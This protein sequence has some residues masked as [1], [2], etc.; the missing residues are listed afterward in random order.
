MAENIYK[1]LKNI[2]KKKIANIVAD[3]LN[4]ISQVS[5]DQNTEINTLKTSFDEVITSRDT[6]FSEV[7]TLMDERSE[8]YQSVITILYLSHFFN[9]AQLDLYNATVWYRLLEFS[10]SEEF[11]NTLQNLKYYITG[12]L[13]VTKT[14]QYQ[15]YFQDKFDTL[16][17]LRDRNLQML[18]TDIG[19]ALQEWNGSVYVTIEKD[20]PEN[21]DNFLFYTLGYLA[22]ATGLFF[23]YTHIMSI[24][25]IIETSNRNLSSFTFETFADEIEKMKNNLKRF[26]I[27]DT[28]RKENEASYTGTYTQD[29]FDKIEIYDFY[30]LSFSGITEETMEALEDDGSFSLLFLTAEDIKSEL[31]ALIYET[32]R[33]ITSI[34]TFLENYALF[35]KLPETNIEQIAKSINTVLDNYWDNLS[36]EDDKEYFLIED[37]NQPNLKTFIYELQQLSNTDD[38]KI[39]FFEDYYNLILLYTGLKLK[40]YETDTYALD[41]IN[42]AVKNLVVKSEV[43]DSEVNEIAFTNL[44]VLEENLSEIYGINVKDNVNTDLINPAIKT[45][46]PKFNIIDLV[47]IS[48]LLDYN[49]G[50]NDSY[51][52]ALGETTYY[53]LDNDTWMSGTI[54]V[55]LEAFINIIYMSVMEAILKQSKNINSTITKT[56]EVY[57]QRGTNF[58]SVFI[59]MIIRK[60]FA[61]LVDYID[62]QTSIINASTITLMQNYLTVDID[63][64]NEGILANYKLVRSAFYTAEENLIEKILVDG[65]ELRTYLETIYE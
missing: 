15:D 37:A 28:Y 31:N 65:N 35:V 17:A 36:D 19:P 53:N 2:L 43:N 29:I 45:L 40:T 56:I 8:A 26:M 55:D 58:K 5:K 60:V 42:Y 24:L 9:A 4:D 1:Q 49:I 39:L 61:K 51:W 18:Q 63:N 54:P 38:E 3:E 23:N 32:L 10:K 34:N 20:D 44:K 16:L 57:Q 7:E 62:G 6:L 46:Y 52:I 48:V 33:S 30:L 64:V 27:L 59:E 14:K 11:T 25:N 22:T 41:Y 21:P 13:T 47:D 50:Y 12:T